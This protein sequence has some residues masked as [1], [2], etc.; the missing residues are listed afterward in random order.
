MSKNTSITNRTR[1]NDKFNRRNEELAIMAAKREE[2]PP[3]ELKSILE[4]C[5]L[6][7]GHKDKLTRKEAMR[8]ASYSSS[9]SFE[10][11][12]NAYRSTGQLAIPRTPGKQ[13]LLSTFS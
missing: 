5:T 8:L 12:I 2:M 1:S 7:R 3:E 4:R 10:K 9:K 13:P 6:D 11:Q